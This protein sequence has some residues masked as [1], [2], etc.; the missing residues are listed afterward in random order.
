MAF[1][2]TTE[3]CRSCDKTVHFIEMVSVD[4]VPYHK[5]CFRCS[6]CKGLLVMGSHCQREGNLY[7][8]PHFEQFFRGTGSYTSKDKPNGLQRAP[9]KVA[10]LF[11]GTQDKCGVCKK[12]CYPLE[13][14][15]VEGEIYHKNCFRCAHGG[16]FLTTSSYAALDGFL[17]CKHHFAQLFKEKGSYSHLTKTSSMKRSP[18]GGK[19]DAESDSEPKSEYNRTGTEAQPDP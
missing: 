16:C 4:G 11:S 8:K 6:H 17:Y 12:T 9:S 18:S 10:S 13:K 3:K 19:F 14:V 5:T 1:S 15:T 2:G 7:C